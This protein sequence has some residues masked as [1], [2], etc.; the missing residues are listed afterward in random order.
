[1]SKNLREIEVRV[2]I[3]EI[4]E[5]QQDGKRFIKMII[6]DEYWVGLIERHEEENKNEL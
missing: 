1:M 3:D 4:E 5:E 2:E 6:D